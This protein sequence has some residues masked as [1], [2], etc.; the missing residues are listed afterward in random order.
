MTDKLLSTA[1]VAQRM[2]P[3]DGTDP[4]TPAFVARRMSS[5]RWP[6]RKIGHHRYMTEADYQAALDIEYAPAVE[7][8]KRRSGVS[9]RSRMRKAS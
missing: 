6:S 5:G 8:P 9:P 3:S 7:V 4:V 2:S 1:E